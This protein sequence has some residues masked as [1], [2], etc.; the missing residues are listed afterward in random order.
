MFDSFFFA[1]LALPS[2]TLNAVN[3]FLFLFA[4]FF[5]IQLDLWPNKS[6]KNVSKS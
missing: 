6:N 2:D 3:D 5:A 4:F 1:F